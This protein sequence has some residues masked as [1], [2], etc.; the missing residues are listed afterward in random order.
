MVLLRVGRHLAE[1]GRL[2]RQHVDV[3]HLEIG[4]RLMSHSQQVEYRVGGAAHGDIQRHGVEKSL[5]GCDATWQHALVTVLVVF[6]SVL[7]NQLGG[8]LEKL[9]AVLVRSHDGAVAR[10]GQADS[11]VQAVHGIGGEHARAASARR[12]GMLLN[13]SHVVVAHRRVG[14]LDHGVYQVEVLPLPF[15]RLHRSA[16]NEDGR[17]VQAHGCHEHARRYLVAVA[18]AHHGVGLV[19]VDHV[20]HAIGNDV[21]RRQGVEHAVVS[22]GDAVVDGD[23]IELGGKAAQF[24]NLF[25]DIL[26]DFVQVD[27]TGYKLRER[28]DDGNDGLSHLLALHAVGHPQRTCPGHAAALR[29]ERT[30]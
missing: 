7:H 20:L 21:A 18:D 10:Q 6:V 25:L 15:A 24:F 17:Y 19:G 9:L 5:A 30:A 1:T 11:L 26:T 22:H 28:V 8:V 3:F 29:T 23:G 13:L 12:A 16:R 27:V 2:A 14:R 4:S